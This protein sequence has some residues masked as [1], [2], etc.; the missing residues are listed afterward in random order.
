MAH[1]HDHAPSAANAPKMAWPK[2]LIIFSLLPL[3][4]YYLALPL[5]NQ[6][7]ATHQAAAEAEKAEQ[8]AQ[9]AAAPAP[10]A[11]DGKTVYEGK[12]AA[13]HQADG[14]GIANVFPPLAGSEWVTGNAS[15]TT[16]I[17]LKGLTGAVKV[18]GNEYNGQMPSWESSLSDA[19]AA[20]VLTYIRSSFGN[21][22]DAVDAA[23]VADIRAKYASRNTPFTAAELTK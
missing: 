15:V 9:A 5:L 23:A 6:S 19:E 12:C 20:A 17:V 16:R 8:A 14:K 2:I 7:E 4:L 22:A 18:A 13:C 10:E 1:E 21:T 11:A 3:V